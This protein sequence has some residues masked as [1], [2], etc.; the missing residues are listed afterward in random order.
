VNV[1]A[2]LIVGFVLVTAGYQSR[3]PL[4]WIMGSI[5]MTVAALYKL[6]SLRELKTRNCEKCRGEGRYRHY[7]PTEDTITATEP[8]DNWEWRD[9]QCRKAAKP[10]K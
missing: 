4:L 3:I 8:G 7:F 9:C 1:F 10:P 2:L 6:G 5:V